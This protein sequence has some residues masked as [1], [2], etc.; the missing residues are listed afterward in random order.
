MME[1]QPGCS[2]IELFSSLS[3][4]ISM[5]RRKNFSREEVTGNPTMISIAANGLNALIENLKL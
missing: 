3:D 4:N 2:D 5:G 1:T